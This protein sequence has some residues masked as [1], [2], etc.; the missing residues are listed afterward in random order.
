[1]VLLLFLLAQLIAA[2][3]YRRQGAVALAVICLIGV[4]PNFRELT[5]AGIFFRDQANRDR[6][7][8]GAVELGRGTISPETDIET[9]ASAETGNVAD[10]GFSVAAYHAAKERFGTPAFSRQQIEA[11]DPVIRGEVD[12]FLVRTLPVTL[13][14]E[15]GKAPFPANPDPVPQNAQLS[16]HGDCLSFEPMFAG[17]TSTLEVPANGL[18]L[19]ASPGPAVPVA[20]K[21]FGD[22]YDSRSAK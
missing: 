19:E 15:G 11:S 18:W 2:S 1:M 13:R 14:P 22:R 8:L 3:P 20:V 12:A 4:L 16:F 7:L 10:L 17:A 5:Y 21:R 6:A 9:S